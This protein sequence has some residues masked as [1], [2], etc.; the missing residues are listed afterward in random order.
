M[1]SILIFSFFYYKFV[2]PHLLSVFPVWSHNTFENLETYNFYDVCYAKIEE[3]G[4]IV[5]NVN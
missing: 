1:L 5:D 3:S 2:V 4:F